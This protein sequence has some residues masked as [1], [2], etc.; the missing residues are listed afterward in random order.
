MLDL[1]EVTEDIGL[2]RFQLLQQ[3][4]VSGVRLAD[5]AEIL[6]SSAV[7]SI[8]QQEWELSPALKGSMMSVIFIGVFFG[9]LMGG[10]FADTYGR[11]LSVL[12][13][14]F[15]LVLCG[16]SSAASTGPG[17]M[18][19]A[20]FLFG[21]F[22][23]FGMGPSLT[24]QVEISPKVWR[25]HMVN[26]NN[27]FFTL[28]EVYA[29]WLLWAFLKDLKQSTEEENW[30]YV[31]A[32]AV[33]PALLILPFAVLL[34]YES[35]HFLAT[36]GK[37]EEAL[38]VVRSMALQNGQAQ[39]VAHLEAKPGLEANARTRLVAPKDTDAQR[40]LVD[41]LFRSEFLPIIV[42]GCY[43]C[44]VANFLFFGLTYAM[45]QVFRV[46]SSP[47]HPATQVL[48][49][50]SADLPACLL[51]S[52]LIRS[53]AYGHRDSLCALAI[54]LAMLLPTLI[55]LEH[56]DP[57]VV[58]SAIYACF[59][60]KCAVTAFFTISYV[61]ITEIFPSACR[62]TAASACMAGGRVGSVIAP[63]AFEMLARGESHVLFW[64]LSSFLCIV[65]VLVIKR[66]L[67]FELKG[68]PLE[69]VVLRRG[70]LRMKRP[71]LLPPEKRVQRCRYT[72]S[73]Q[74]IPWKKEDY[75]TM[76]A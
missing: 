72:A 38:S 67:T 61:Y 24:L 12:L 56:K 22:Y 33:S 15:G 7:L 17:F 51:A 37:H 75:A 44:F 4:L 32:L 18:L 60:A 47:F 42:G 41:V 64:L 68:E 49:V 53:K 52:M 26:V 16:L 70:D 8:L 54:V 45:P 35:P 31:T 30:R 69:D 3:L 5:G 27:F 9:N 63:F 29:A 40:S 65:A 58:M 2:G 55:I 62:C 11:R 28:G 20:R 36:K 10:P 57:T 48:V 59:L 13:A 74:E 21:L 14:Y 23:G 19:A 6:I 25:G 39:A 1:D 73:A 76:S 46:V 66:C 50:T 34:L 43:I 71:S